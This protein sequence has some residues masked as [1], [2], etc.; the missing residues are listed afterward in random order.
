MAQENSGYSIPQER[1]NMAWQYSWTNRAGFTG[2]TNNAD[3]VY[4]LLTNDYGWT[5]QAACAVLAN[6]QAESYINPSQW[7]IGSTIGDWDDSQTGLGLGQWTP[8][9]KLA[10]YVGSTDQ[11]AYRDGDIQ[12][13]FLVSDESQW[14]NHYLHPDGSAPYYDIDYAPYYTSIASFSQATEAPALLALTWMACWERPSAA[15]S[16]KDTRQ[17]NAIHWDERYSQSGYS[18]NIIIQGQGNAYATPTRAQ[19]GTSVTITAIPNNGNSF[20][21]WLI[22]S[23]GIILD[24]PVGITPNS[25]TMGTDNVTLYAIFTDDPVPPTPT[26]SYKEKRTPIWMYPTLRC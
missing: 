8:P 21:G 24:Q 26:G 22:D 1:H 7:Q 17:A 4:S 2:T 23:G 19:T 11:S 14:N 12:V 18:T 5:H 6:L 3:I 20:Q 10:N 25:F 15:Y 13:Q 9:R 16:H